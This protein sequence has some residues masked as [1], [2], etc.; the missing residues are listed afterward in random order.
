LNQGS[1][2]YQGF[3]IAYAGRSAHPNE[4][5]TFAECTKKYLVRERKANPELLIVT[6]GGYRDEFT[7]ELFIMPIDAYPPVLTPTVSPRKVR[8]LPEAFEPCGK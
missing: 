2:H 3:I 5:A 4:A 8:I 6:D 1:P 7:V